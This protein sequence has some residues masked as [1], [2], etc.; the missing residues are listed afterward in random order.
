MATG[1]EAL[2]AKLFRNSFEAGPSIS[3]FSYEE[4]SGISC[5]GFRGRPDEI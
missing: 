2:N 5:S 4:I 1:G 3:N